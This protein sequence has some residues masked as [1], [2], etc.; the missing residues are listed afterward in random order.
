MFLR[1]LC[2]GREPIGVNARAHKKE[3][4]SMSMMTIYHI[5]DRT[6]VELGENQHVGMPD[7]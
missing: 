7:V 6:N 4:A 1:L 2:K 3:T 5:L